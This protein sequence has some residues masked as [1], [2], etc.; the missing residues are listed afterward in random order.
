MHPQRRG[1]G[2]GGALLTAAQRRLTGL[3][4][5]AAYAKV[6]DDPAG[7]GFAQRR[8]YRRGRRAEFLMLDL[9]EAVL[10]A[11]PVLPA[12]VRL[13]A[14][15]EL[16]GPHPLCTADL[17]ASRDEP[18][19]VTMDEVGYA[20]WLAAYWE[21]P[22]LDRELT[23]VAVRDGEVLA[24]GFAMADRRDRYRSGMTGT[25]RGHRGRGLARAVKQRSLSRVRAAGLRYAYTSNDAGN[26]AM[27][28]L[29][30]RLGYRT[31]AAEWHYLRDLSD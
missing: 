19:E 28:T 18:G 26:V 10:P 4:A 25:R 31:V 2:A 5:V 14:A 23:T 30:R 11:H 8:G 9:A 7:V 15:A 24:F 13:L 29:N 20:D 3:G 12:G 17:H 6:A 16:P 21:R 1:R 22:D 27:L